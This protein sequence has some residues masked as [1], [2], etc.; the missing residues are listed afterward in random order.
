MKI[1]KSN[2]LCQNQFSTWNL[3]WMV[4]QIT[5]KKIPTNKLYQYQ[6]NRNYSCPPCLRVH[7][8]NAW[9]FFDTFLTPPPPNDILLFVPLF[10][11]IIGNVKL[12]SKKVPLKPNLTIKTFNWKT[13]QVHVENFV[14]LPLIKSHVL[15]EWRL[16]YYLCLSICPSVVQFDVLLMIFA[17]P[18]K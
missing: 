9:H 7:S 14:N 15:I 10:F 16:R 1:L 6:F 13:K 8:N 11:K 3:S 5:K 2:I 17:V 4:S 12:I 18:L